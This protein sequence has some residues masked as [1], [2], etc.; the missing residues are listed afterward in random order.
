LDGR[1]NSIP[2]GLASRIGQLPP[3]GE[4]AERV[5]ALEGATERRVVHWRLRAAGAHIEQRLVAGLA[6]GA[7]RT[8]DLRL[9]PLP[10]RG[11]IV[12]VVEREALDAVRARP[13]AQR[14]ADVGATLERERARAGQLD[15]AADPHAVAGG[16]VE[17][18]A[19]DPLVEQDAESRAAAGGP[20]RG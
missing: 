16:V 18:R 4:H 6:R 15:R 14:A 7:E 20:A 12:R 19:A 11:R 10:E 8:Q 9:L 3:A 1:G 2:R 5:E 13:F 17:G